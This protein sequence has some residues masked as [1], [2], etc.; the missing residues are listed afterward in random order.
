MTLSNQIPFDDRI[1]HQAKMAD[2]NLT[3]IKAYLHEI[4]SSLFAEADKADFNRLCLSRGIA[5]GRRECLK[6]K[7][8]GLLFFSLEPE[9]HIPGARIDV[10][11]F[12]EDAGG[13]RI[14]EIFPRK[15]N[16]PSPKPPCENYP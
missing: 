14:E 2:L 12:W 1:C 10:T 9:K 15:T 4:E 11:E 16:L 5:G 7:Y 6:P 13:V 8:A 3:L